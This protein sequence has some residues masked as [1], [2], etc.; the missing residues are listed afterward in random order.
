MPLSHVDVY[1]LTV[2]MNKAPT[3]FGFV[4]KAQEKARIFENPEDFV[5]YFCAE[6]MEVMRRWVLG[7]RQV[8]VSNSVY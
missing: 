7:L 4:L 8:K 1:T 5:F 6:N 2:P 3:D